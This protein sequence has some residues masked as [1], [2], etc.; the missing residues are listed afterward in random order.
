MTA[1]S[2]MQH[3][4]AL[5]TTDPKYTKAVS[6]QTVESLDRFWTDNTV[7]FDWIGECYVNDD[8]YW[9]EEEPTDEEL[10]ETTEEGEDWDYDRE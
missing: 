1:N 3:W 4:D 5:K 2:K 10:G 8:P 6:G 7:V 9:F